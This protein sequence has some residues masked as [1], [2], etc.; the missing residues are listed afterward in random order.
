[1]ITTKQKYK[2]LKEDYKIYKS[3][4]VKLV[5]SLYKR[6]HYNEVQHNELVKS[7]QIIGDLLKD[8]HTFLAKK[9]DET[10]ELEYYAQMSKISLAVADREEEF[11]KA[12]E[13]IKEKY[14]VK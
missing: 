4:T 8:N 2:D 3:A 7:L 10:R 11:A 6:I 13:D 1:M 9:Y 5:S 14:G 12:M